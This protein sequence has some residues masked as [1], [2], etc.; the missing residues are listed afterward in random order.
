MAL[1]IAAVIAG[2]GVDP[3]CCAPVETCCM[4]P[5]QG[6]TD[7]LYT[8]DDLPE[9]LTIKYGETTIE[10]EKL[11]GYAQYNEVG[12]GGVDTWQL[13]NAGG[14]W[15]IE[16]NG[17]DCS[18]LFE[19]L[20]GT[21]PLTDGGCGPW[22]IEQTGCSSPCPSEI[23]VEDQFAAEYEV[24]FDYYF[25]L[26]GGHTY[27]YKATVVRISLCVWETTIIEHD[28]YEAPPITPDYVK[29]EY[30]EGRWQA[31]ASSS[32]EGTDGECEKVA[33]QGSPNKN[34]DVGE[35]NYGS[36]YGS[37]H[38]FDFVVVDP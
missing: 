15:E 4:Y 16:R 3:C 25:E 17:N 18:Y 8:V 20:I 26:D 23:T 27:R 37:L 1:K 5:A 10:M 22:N 14:G 35:Y 33:R 6:L 34:T 12:G 13:F 30:W 28:E 11:S 2:S 24:G 31:Y 19:C 7:E 9:F 32:I 29:L 38:D 36:L 21:H